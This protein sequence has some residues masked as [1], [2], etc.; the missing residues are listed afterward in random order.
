M[1]SLQVIEVSIGFDRRPLWFYRGI[2]LVESIG[3]QS[4]QVLSQVK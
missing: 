3:V 1:G 4:L 2:G